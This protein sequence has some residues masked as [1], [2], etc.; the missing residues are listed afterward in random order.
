[1]EYDPA[2]V[3]QNEWLLTPEYAL[4]SG[5][6]SVWSNGSVYWC[7]TD[8]DNC[9]M[10]VWLVVG[11]VGGGDDVFVGKLDD[12]W[13]A[14]WTGLSPPSTWMRWFRVSRFASASNTLGTMALRSS[15][16]TSA[17]MVCWV[18]M[19]RGSLNLITGSLAANGGSSALD[20]YFDAT[21]L[22]LGTYTANLR[23]IDDK[24]RL[25]EVP[26]TLNVV[27]FKMYLP[28]ITR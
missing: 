13:T 10:N 26:V 11:A 1:M 8:F 18:W 5:T 4:A 24:A 12:S 22:A 23:I 14:S 19:S 7:K 6:L 21:G 16:M 20:V 17:W 15:L 3:D 25:V 27:G 28:L 2:L 9:D